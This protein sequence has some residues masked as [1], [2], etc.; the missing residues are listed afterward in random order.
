VLNL[1]LDRVHEEQF[2]AAMQAE[3]AQEVAA[4]IRSGATGPPETARG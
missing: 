3:V 4:S 1:D 2:L